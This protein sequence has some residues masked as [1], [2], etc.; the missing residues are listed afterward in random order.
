MLLHLSLSLSLSL[1]FNHSVTSPFRTFS[2]SFNRASADGLRRTLLRANLLLVDGA[3]KQL[4]QP[5]TVPLNLDLVAYHFVC[6]FE[7]ARTFRAA[8]LRLPVA[9]SACAQNTPQHNKKSGRY[10]ELAEWRNEWR[11]KNG[12]CCS[13]RPGGFG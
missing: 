9:Y 11:N 7:K 5:C 1:R 6:R 8:I 3:Q 13:D 12:R 4:R 10:T 2:W